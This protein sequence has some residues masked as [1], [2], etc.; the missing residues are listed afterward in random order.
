MGGINGRKRSKGEQGEGH[1]LEGRR[2]TEGK[3]EMR[4]Q[5]GKPNASSARNKRD[6]SNSFSLKGAWVGVS[7]FSTG[8]LL[9]TGPWGARC[10]RD[11]KGMCQKWRWQAVHA[12]KRVPRAGWECG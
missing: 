10:S 11:S 9:T 7:Q 1:G 8:G 4:G 12:R 6:R 5:G 2:S 3:G